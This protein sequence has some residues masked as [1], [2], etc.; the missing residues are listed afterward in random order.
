[1]RKNGEKMTNLEPSGCKAFYWLIG[2]NRR[3]CVC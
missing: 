2:E 3:I 1:M